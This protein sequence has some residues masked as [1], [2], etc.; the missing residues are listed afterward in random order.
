M[1]QFPDTL[2]DP[3]EQFPRVLAVLEEGVR[4]H[5]HRGVQ[6]YVSHRG[7]PLADFA[8]GERAP[9][10]PLSRRARMLWLSSGKPLTVVALARLQEQ[11][12]F[13]WSTPVV[14]LLPE[15]DGAGTDGLTLEHL[16]TH[17]SGLDVAID[18]GWPSM[19]WSDILRRITLAARRIEQLPGSR[20][21]YQPA[22]TWFLLGEVISRLTDQPFADALRE[23]VLEPLRMLQ[24]HNGLSPQQWE[25]LQH[26]LVPVEQRKGG[27]LVPLQRHEPPA[28]TSPSPGGNTWG[29]VAELG[30]LYEM[31]LAEGRQ[32]DGSRFLSAKTVQ[33]LTRPHRSGEFDHTFGHIVDFGLGVIVDSTRYGPETVPYGFGRHASPAAFGHGGAQSSIGFADPTSGLVVAWAANGLAGEGWHQRRNRELNTA[34]YEDLGLATGSP[35]AADARGTVNESPAGS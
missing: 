15:L 33:T 1:L 26:D 24:T 17:T 14:E 5:W 27:K 6:L 32:P 13:G 18:S 31:L 29:P 2:P 35:A 10:E 11:S 34:I 9:G 23:L 20:A 19:P 16:L 8:F 4:R 28:A 30:R 12:L 21:A 22:L 3:R 7:S 25:T